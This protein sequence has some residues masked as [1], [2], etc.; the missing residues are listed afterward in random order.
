MHKNEA[1][2]ALQVGKRLTHAYFTDG[3]WVIMLPNGN[4]QFE[5]GVEI[6]PDEFWG[7]R[8]SS[9]WETDWSIHAMNPTQGEWKAI[10]NHPVFPHS[11]IIAVKDEE[12]STSFRDKYKFIAE[13]KDV[14][15]DSFT[16]LDAEE[17]KANIALIAA[18]P[19]LLAA[20][21]MA[22]RWFENNFHR[23]DNGQDYFNIAMVEQAIEKTKFNLVV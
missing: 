4:Y 1:I 10:D 11:T 20:L 18:A 13:V 21:E 12:A 14:R 16:R 23:A 22:Q 8:K 5:D 15:G 6:T 19:E 17:R 7:L 2:L 9:Y 3:E